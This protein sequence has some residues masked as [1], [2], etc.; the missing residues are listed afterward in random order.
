[1]TPGEAGLRFEDFFE[2]VYPRLLQGAFL[3]VGD[4]AEAEDLAQEAM[5][6]AYE[7]WYR[8]RSMESPAGYVFRT[9]L[10]LRRKA[11][12]RLAARR[13]G[14]LGSE[15]PPPD[16][17]AVAEARDLVERVLASLPQSQREA[18]VLV[19]LIGMDAREAGSVLG[20]QPE[21]V[22]VRVHRAR[23]AVQANLEVVE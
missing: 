21:S 5:V 1:M 10:N 15:V 18:L 20:I 11:L 19:D 13:R 6:R 22:R 4:F 7:R 8:V 12:R 16:P 14:R 2:A 9:A 3:L 17:A 23:K